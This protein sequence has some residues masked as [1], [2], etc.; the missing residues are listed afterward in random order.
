MMADLLTQISLG[1]SHHH[2]C[3]FVEPSSMA[4]VVQRGVYLRISYLRYVTD[5]TDK[6]LEIFN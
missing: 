6:N 3:A 4:G 1:V 5:Y 2:V